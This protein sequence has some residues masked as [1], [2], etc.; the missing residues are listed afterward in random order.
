VYTPDWRRAPVWVLSI[1]LNGFEKLQAEHPRM[2]RKRPF[3][4]IEWILVFDIV[5]VKGVFVAFNSIEW[6]PGASLA[7]LIYASSM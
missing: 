7:S 3:N 2:S 6:I 5:R 4:S 1:P